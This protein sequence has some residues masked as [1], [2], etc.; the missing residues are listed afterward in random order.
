LN[1]ILDRLPGSLTI[2]GVEYLIDTDFRT[3]ILFELMM[4]DDEMSD[5]DKAQETIALYFPGKK[6]DF[7]EETIDKILW[8]YRGGKEEKKHR[9]SGGGD[10]LNPVYSFEHD[11]F[12]IYSAFLEQ[13]GI[14]LTTIK[15]MHWWKFKALFLSLNDQVLFTKIMGYRSVKIEKMSKEQKRFYMDMKRMYALPKS[16][17]VQEKVDA[18][19]EALMNG[20]DI[21]KLMEGT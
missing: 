18:I 9:G 5:E 1:L 15:Y 19:Q 16:K 11:D 13:Y 10:P 4:L 20:G 3:S 8:F 12:Y 21:S 17:S 2:G 7:T 14:D 6:P